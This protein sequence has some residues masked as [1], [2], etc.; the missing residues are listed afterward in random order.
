MARRNTN[1]AV[2]EE[3]IEVIEE[4]SG[5]GMG[6][7]VGVCALTFITLAVATVMLMMKLGSDYG[8][9]PFGG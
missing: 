5:P 2:V 6:I 7:D 9:G 1:E 8:V 3:P 4:E